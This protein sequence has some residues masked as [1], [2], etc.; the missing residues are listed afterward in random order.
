MRVGFS[1]ARAAALLVLAAVIGSPAG[2]QELAQ[3][4]FTQSPTDPSFNERLIYVPVNLAFSGRPAAQP[5]TLSVATWYVQPLGAKDVRPDKTLDD[6]AYT[7][8]QIELLN[9]S[10]SH[11][12]VRVVISRRPAPPEGAA[13][14]LDLVHP[15]GISAQRVTATTEPIQGGIRYTFVVTPP[16]WGITSRN[17][18]IRTGGDTPRYEVRLLTARD[19]RP[20]AS[21]VRAP[22]F[23]GYNASAK[24]SLPPPQLP[25]IERV[26]GKRQEFRNGK[27]TKSPKQ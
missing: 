2:A 1:A 24:D 7:L 18:N 12:Q 5:Y 26:A 17:S 19:V 3:R 9:G 4:R 25:Y 11:P 21:V 10:G 13:P 8:D 23:S 16:L 27:V 22:T 6:A 20:P 15:S 14:Q